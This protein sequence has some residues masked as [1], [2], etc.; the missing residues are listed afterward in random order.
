MR[1]GWAR[2]GQAIQKAVCEHLAAGRPFGSRFN[3]RR[4]RPVGFPRE[5]Y[6]FCD[7]PK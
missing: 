3:I 6:S 4:I 1:Y 2:F 5:V 7:S